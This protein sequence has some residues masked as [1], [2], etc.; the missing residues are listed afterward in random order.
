MAEGSV[1]L[2]QALTSLGYFASREQTRRALLAGE[3]EVNGSRTEKPGL[4][5]QLRFN[6]AG[7]AFLVSK[8]KELKIAIREKMPYVSRG[9]YK[10]AAGLDCAKIDPSGM[11]C[12]DIGASTGGFTD[13]LL[14]RGAVKVFAVDC[15][16][17]QLHDKIRNDERVVVMEKT[18]ARF[19]TPEDLGERPAL[20]VADV[21]F[22]SL[23]LIIPVIK[24]CLSE[25]GRAVVLVKPQFEVGPEKL[26]KGGVVKDENTRLEAL[27]DI[28]NFFLGQGFGIIAECESPVIGP[29]G[30]HE[31]LLAARKL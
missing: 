29:A 16:H 22:I 27:K 5:V 6:E 31:F 14:Q 17:G 11:V 4:P 8:G 13:V 24:N 9:G 20:A 26:S 10:L 3:V 12:M 23:K 19:L 18:N 7:E 25:K 28:K 21:S 30:N 2:D 1:R 15:G